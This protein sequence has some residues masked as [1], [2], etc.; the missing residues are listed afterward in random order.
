MASAL[1]S[2]VKLCVAVVVA[3]CVLADFLY[4]SRTAAYLALAAQPDPIAAEMC[5]VDPELPAEKSS[6]A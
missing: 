4:L 1:A 3:Y 5:I 2:Y 6:S